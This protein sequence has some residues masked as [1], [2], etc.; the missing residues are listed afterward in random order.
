MSVINFV[1][2]YLFKKKKRSNCTN[3]QADF[4]LQPKHWQ[5]LCPIIEKK[6]KSVNL[7]YANFI[8]NNVLSD[9]PAADTIPKS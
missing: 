3:L 2:N 1:L 4:H 7:T 8:P 5:F 6:A 9:F